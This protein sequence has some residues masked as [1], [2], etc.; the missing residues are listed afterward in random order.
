MYLNRPMRKQSH[1]LKPNAIKYKIMGN[2]IRNFHNANTEYFRL[3]FKM[4]IVSKILNIN[5]SISKNVTINFH[6]IFV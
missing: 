6:L 3:G 5:V 4:Y 2:L 1:F